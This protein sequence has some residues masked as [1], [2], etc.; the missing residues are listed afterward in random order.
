MHLIN[1]APGG[2]INS[3]F[4]YTYNALGLE[5]SEDTLDGDWTYTYDAEGELIH[6]VFASTNPSVPSQ[7]LAYTYDAMG[8]RV[9]TFVNSVTTAYT[10]NDMNEYTSVGGVAHTYDVDGNLLTDGT[11]SYSYN[12]L[13]QLISIAGPSGTT[14]YTYNALGQH[15]AS[16]TNGETTQYLIDPSGLGNVVGVYSG[17]GLVADYIY[18]LGLTSQST[19]NGTFFYDFDASG[20]TSEVTGSTG[21]VGASYFYRPSGQEIFS[22][23]T[24]NNPFQFVGQF[25]VMQ[26]SNSLEDMRARVYDAS[27]GRFDSRDPLGSA[28]GSLNYYEYAENEPQRNSDPSGLFLPAIILV[29]EG[30]VEEVGWFE[31]PWWFDAGDI[32][33]NVADAFEDFGSN[34]DAGRDNIPQDPSLDVQRAL[35]QET[36]PA[37]SPAPMPPDSFFQPY[38]PPLVTDESSGGDGYYPPLVPTDAGSQEDPSPNPDPADDG[39]DGDEGDVGDC[40]DADSVDPNSL[41]GPAGYGSSNFVTDAGTILPYQ[42]NFENASSATAPAQAV[43]ITDQLDPNLNWGTFQLTGIQWGDTILSIPAGSQYFQATV[44]MTYDGETFDVLVE[45]GIHTATGQVYATFQSINPITDLPPDVLIGFLPPEN[46]TGRGMGDIGFTIQPN[47]GLATGT[48]IR[49]VAP[50]HVRLQ[51]PDCHRPGQR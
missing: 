25:G 49:N 20:S 21:T 19:T 28:G 6:A 34:D 39:D 12:S 44:P 27:A 2:A 51:Q 17:S 9:T 24:S 37:V 1:Y 5:T 26:V 15:V 38:Y 46:G 3:R 23:G 45:T 36:G 40:E 13:N 33:H 47:A 14:T 43:T 31:I 8:N 41:L 4:D 35:D 29:G 16:T 30:I 18:G 42:I 11:N 22:E 50:D 10:T 32:G 7:N 48:Q